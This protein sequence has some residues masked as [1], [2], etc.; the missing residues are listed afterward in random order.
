MKKVT[1][2]ALLTCASLLGFSQEKATELSK[3]EAKEEY[4][5]IL[6]STKLLS[7]KV[8]I[9]VDFGQEWSFWKDKR[10]LKDANGKK[11]EFDSVIDALNYMSSQGWEFVNAYSLTTSGQNVLHYVMKRDLKTQKVEEAA[12]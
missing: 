11:L 9:A 3:K 7:T 10:S 8:N 4:C 12:S 5:M 1:L 2:I 6:A